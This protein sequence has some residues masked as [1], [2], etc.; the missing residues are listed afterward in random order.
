MEFAV[1][2]VFLLAII[3][4]A[5][6]VGLQKKEIEE[7]EPMPTIHTSGIYS[8][9][10]QSPRENVASAKPSKHDLRAFV[11]GA[12]HDINRIPLSPQ[13]K[14]GLLSDWESRLE[15]AL[16]LVE[17]GD[18][19]GVQRFLIKTDMACA[20]CQRFRKAP[21]FFTREDIHNFPGLLPPFY[22]GCTCRLSPESEWDS[23]GFGMKPY[24]V[25]NSETVS[26]PDWRKLRK[27][28]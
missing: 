12:T 14:A 27:T 28:G 13:D 25:K 22:P 6:Y 4:L 11:E 17:E 7:E 18:R 19:I 8:V 9:I 10:R 26:V 2:F 15:Q 5:M 21:Y 24:V 3:V 23:P 20:P 16:S 1:G